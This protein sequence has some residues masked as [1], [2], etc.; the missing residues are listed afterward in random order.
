MKT[1]QDLKQLAYD[2]HRGTYSNPEYTSTKFVED[3]TNDLN[4][5]LEQIPSDY[6]SWV[7]EKYISLLSKWLS[8][9]TSIFS[10]FISGRSNYPAKRMQKLNGWADN[11]Y[12]N[13]S[14]WRENIVKRVKR[15]EKKKNYSLSSEIEEKHEKLSELQDWQEKMKA[16]NKIVRSKKLS[17]IE[18]NEELTVLYGLSEQTIHKLLNPRYSY[19]KKGFQ[20]WQLSNNN[21]TIRNTKAR[22]KEL[23]RRLEAEGQDNE[24]YEVKGVRVELD[25]AENRVKLFFPRKPVKENRR[26]L[27]N[28]GFRWSYNNDCWQAYMSAEPRVKAMLENM[29]IRYE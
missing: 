26:E 23:E 5:L 20:G 1:I 6:H 8:S 12:K 14:D 7:R 13:F 3:Y 15:W 27:S 21:A 29:D 19:E 24:E 10:P 17:E 2:A 4:D 22:I 11:H 25:I 16:I 18:I 9:Q 28:N